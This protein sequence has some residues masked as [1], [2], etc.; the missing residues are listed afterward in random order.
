MFVCVCV[1]A[2]MCMYVCTR[3]CVKRE[4]NNIKKK[5]K[6][7]KVVS[8]RHKQTELDYV[9]SGRNRSGSIH[10]QCVCSARSVL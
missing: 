8:Y 5:E 9:N 2:C 1:N 10:R 3:V 7:K 4:Q 6:K